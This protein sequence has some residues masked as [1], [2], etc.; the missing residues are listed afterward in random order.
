MNVTS[1]TE[2]CHQDLYLLYTDFRSAFNT[3]N[4]D[5]LL[6]TM[7]DLGSPTDAT[8]VKASLYTDATTRINLNFALTDHIELGR[9]TMQGVIQI[10]HSVLDN[11]RLSV[12]VAATWGRGYRYQCLC[13]IPNAGHTTSNL[14]YA[15]DLAAMT[16]SIADRKVQPQ[17]IQAFVTWS[18][19]TV[20]WKPCAITGMMYGQAHKDRSSKALSTSMM[21]ML[22]D[23]ARQTQIHGTQIPFIHPHLEPYGYLEPI[24]G[25]PVST[26]SAMV[27]LDTEQAGLALPL[28]MVTHEEVSCRH[29]V[30]PVNDCGSLGF[31]TPNLLLVFCC[32][33]TVALQQ[34]SSACFRPP[35]ITWH[36]SLPLCKMQV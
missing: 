30:Q 16:I 28:L 27:H 36:D 12:E 4:D 24:N 1:D 20:N 13:N 23:R 15:D 17:K 9:G 32:K 25:M 22:R 21:H 31:I 6:N 14:A 11:H 19:T 26:T 29:L 18:G 10:A 2:I 3:V 7:Y 34:K 5:K 33:A 8:G 35:T